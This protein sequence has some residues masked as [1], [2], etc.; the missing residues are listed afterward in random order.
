MHESRS[1]T[2]RMKRRV[3]LCGRPLANAP[4]V[5][6]FCGPCTRNLAS[7][8]CVVSG[9]VMPFLRFTGAQ[10]CAPEIRSCS[11]R[12]S[13]SGR[14][15]RRLSS[16]AA[17]HLFL[18]FLL[19][20][21]ARGLPQE[22]SAGIFGIRVF[23]C[24]LIPYFPMIPFFCWDL[25]RSTTMEGGCQPSSNLEGCCIIF[26]TASES[27]GTSGVRR[28]SRSSCLRLPIRPYDNSMTFSRG[29]RYPSLAR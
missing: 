14:G 10:G 2:R 9:W 25:R 21:T 15:G 7:R 13:S 1:H 11:S 6:P 24:G 4:K 27:G 5:C 19:R 8:A 29:R 26:V 23:T 17:Y 3:M 20:L 12:A 28:G 16:A 22:F 18:I